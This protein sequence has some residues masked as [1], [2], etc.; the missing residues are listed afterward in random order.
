MNIAVEP[1]T[2]PIQT[3]GVLDPSVS[4]IDDEKEL[5]QAFA[6]TS[7]AGKESYAVRRGGTFVSE[8]PREDEDGSHSIGTPE[9]PNHLLGA[10]PWLFPYGMG[11]FEVN[12]PI[13]L[14]YE[15]HAKWALKYAD[16]R[17]RKDLQFMF[18]VF[19]VI[20]KRQVCRSAAIQ[21]KKKDFLNHCG[22]F[23][24]LK[25]SDL[26]TAS[27]EEDHH[28]PCSNPVVRSLKRHISVVRS[29]VMG[30]DESRMKVRSLVWGMV[31]KKSPPSLWIIINPSDTHNPIAQLFT[32]AEIDLDRF[33]RTSGPDS[34]QRSIR[35]AS[36]PYAA[37]HFFHFTIT[38]ILKTVF[39]ISCLEGTIKRKEGIF[40]YVE[41]Y[42]GTVE[43][44]GQGTLHLHMLLWLRGAP[45]A[46][47]MKD[48]LQSDAFQQ[49]M[50]TF[51]SNNIRASIEKDVD[52][53]SYDLPNDSSISYARP[54]H[55]HSTN[56]ETEH[57]RVQQ[58]LA[59][60]VQTHK[61]GPACMIVVKGSFIS[62]VLTQLFYFYSYR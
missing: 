58:R 18:Q 27:K 52:E 41:A 45:T 40:G 26:W 32:G 24:C 46:T 4:D 48:L 50:A 56:Y 21:V 8:Y 7:F 29:H 57:K 61:C 1:S 14:S 54:V 16:G 19:G 53:D 39:G 3:Y 60:V 12:R 17:F 13:A 35:I 37:A 51:I 38:T 55:P 30:T 43:A 49:R 22:A 62:I 10:F 59:K 31:I 11:G 47:R 2:I 28:G 23:Q 34:Y 20:Q 9:N 44:Q 33:E 36:D 25:P 6:N 42:I 15:A 5:A